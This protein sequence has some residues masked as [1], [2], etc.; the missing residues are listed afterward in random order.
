MLEDLEGT[1]YVE[2]S[3]SSRI[4]TAPQ[5]QRVPQTRSYVPCGS[6]AASRPTQIS[7][8]LPFLAHLP[9]ASACSRSVIAQFIR[10]LHGSGASSRPPPVPHA[11]GRRDRVRHDPNPSRAPYAGP[12]KT[13][14]IPRSSISLGHHPRAQHGLSRVRR[15][16]FARSRSLRPPR[17]RYHKHLLR[18]PRHHFGPRL[19]RRSLWLGCNQAHHRLR[20]TLFRRTRYLHFKRQHLSSHGHALLKCEGYSKRSRI[21]R[22]LPVRNLT[23]WRHWRDVWKKSKLSSTSIVGEISPPRM[24]RTPPRLSPSLK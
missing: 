20:T 1:P 18:K 3:N 2:Y 23:P 8:E 7:I 17:S 14:S 13:R 5:S 19:P 11:F 22:I 10:S 21:H 12:I 15:R 6:R 16:F 4:F 24:H 9:G